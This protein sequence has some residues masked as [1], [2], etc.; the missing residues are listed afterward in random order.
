MI[1]YIAKRT[2]LM[3]PTIVFISFISF[4]I[5][6][7]P[8]GDFLTT[9]VAQLAASGSQVSQ[10]TLDA[11]REAYGIGQPFYVQYF[12][13]IS[14]ILLH[15]DFGVSFEWNQPISDFI[16]G[17]I[18]LT[19][20]V[21]GI[22]LVVT[23][24]VAF[25]IGVLSAVRQYSLADYGATFLAFLGLAVPD[26]ILALVL[27]IGAFTFFGTDIAGLFSAEF[28]DAPWSLQKFA[29]MLGHLWAPVIVLA[30][31]R[32][33]VL[34]RV[35]RANLLDELQ[36]PYVTAARAKG[37]S[38]TRV[39]VR[40]PVRAALNPFVSTVGWELPNLISGVTIVS[41][42]LSLPTTGPLLLKSLLSQDMYLAAAFILILS[43][44]TLIGTLVSDIL[45]A[46]LDPRIRLQGAR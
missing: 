15:G 31:A 10:S 43:V 6:V 37:L 8:P 42:V 22:A 14:G 33:A 45:L 32:T 16:W 20:I 40:Y 18:G 24:L 27:M 7:L 2:F 25:P 39:L 26:Y 29:D 41:V 36:K 44:L 21:S 13:W 11:L 12:R 28:A 5:I 9:Y 1:A 46:A 3:I 38:E 19:L 17:R 35:M 34:V 23:W 4:G 30:V